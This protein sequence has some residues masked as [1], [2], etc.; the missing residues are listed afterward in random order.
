M[1]ITKA[2]IGATVLL[3]LAL[4]KGN[5]QQATTSSGSNASGSGGSVSWS[6]GLVTY[7][8][9]IGITGSVSQGV[10]QASQRSPVGTLGA[11]SPITLSVFPNPATNNFVLQ[12]PGYS[13][14][15]LTYQL[16]DMQGRLLESN[17]II[18]IQTI[19]YTHN[20]PSSTYFLNII[21]GNKQIHSF[22]IIKK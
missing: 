7:S 4:T 19:I 2:K 12:I 5:A 9:S 13:H 10:Q 1:M 15:K 8:T 14:Q 17:S 16:F 18:G 22:T 20:I 3:A 21:Q 11:E 6:V